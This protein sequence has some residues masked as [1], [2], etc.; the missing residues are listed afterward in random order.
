MDVVVRQHVSSAGVQDH[1]DARYHAM[2]FAAQVKHG[3]GS[4]PE[5][6]VEQH[7]LVPDD[8]VCQNVR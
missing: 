7:L 3:T 2:F 8:E 5:E 1:D 6:Q 4:R